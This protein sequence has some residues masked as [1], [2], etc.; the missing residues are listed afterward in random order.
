M[1]IRWLLAACALAVFALLPGSA[2]A[3]TGGSFDGNDHPYVAYEDNGV[4]ACSGTLLS[5]TVMLTA[6]HCFSDSTSAWDT[7]SVTGAP[8]VR[9]T[10]DPDI[11]GTPRDERVWYFGSYYYDPGFTIGA[12]GGLPGFDTHDVAVIIFTPDGCTVPPDTVASG[13]KSCGPIPGSATDNQYGTLPDEGLV[14]TLAQ[15][16]PVGLVGYGVQGFLRGGGPCFD[17]VG[18]HAPC[19]PLE[20]ALFQRY[21]AQTTL[22]ASN[23]RISGEFIKLHANKGGTCFGDSGGPNLLGDTNTVLAVNSFVANNLCAGNTYSYRVDTS[24]ALSWI[25]STVA[26]KGGSLP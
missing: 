6:A 7:N 20:V 12:G 18:G 2:A 19:T 14:D 21:A 4:F 17:A 9:V 3:V 25:T 10:F 24:E 13:V 11:P 23:D 26:A 1:R 5:P 22:I 8:L 15:K 16:T